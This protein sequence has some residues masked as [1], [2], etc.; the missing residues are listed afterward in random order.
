[1]R[2]RE[3]LKHA[4][5]NPDSQYMIEAHRTTNNVTYE[6]A[7]RDL[8]SL[9]NKALLDKVKKGKKFY[10]TPSKHLI[11]TLKSQ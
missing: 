11:K 2:Q 10:Y 9:Q 5:D 8:A 3:L 1:M 6:T 4:M 7:R